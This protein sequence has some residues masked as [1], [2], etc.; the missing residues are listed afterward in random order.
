M[1]NSSVILIWNELVCFSRQVAKD[2]MTG[3]NFRRGSEANSV[4]QTEPRIQ[5][6]FI[7]RSLDSKRD[8]SA[9]HPLHPEEYDTKLD[10]KIYDRWFGYDQELYCSPSIIIIIIIYLCLFYMCHI[11]ITSKAI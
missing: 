1:I 7:K 4:A 3:Y 9:L 2:N 5:Y 11:I 10:R 6:V 8:T